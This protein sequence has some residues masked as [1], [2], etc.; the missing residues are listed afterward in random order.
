MRTTQCD[1]HHRKADRGGARYKSPSNQ[2]A[3]Q[4]WDVTMAMTPQ[5]SAKSTADR[6][7]TPIVK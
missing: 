6:T 2:I 5:A 1:R 3:R 4:I 7:E